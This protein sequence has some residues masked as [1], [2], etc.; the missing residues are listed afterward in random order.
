MKNYM[1]TSCQLERMWIHT[2]NHKPIKDFMPRKFVSRAE[3]WTILS[4]ILWWKKHEAS[5]NSSKYYVEHLNSLK[6]D[7]ILNNIDPTLKERRS[8]AVLMVYRAAK[9]LGKA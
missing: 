1:V 4:R 2:A 8:Y 6:N 5:K 7:N 3:F 9:S